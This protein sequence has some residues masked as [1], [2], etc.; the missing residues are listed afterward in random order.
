MRLSFGVFFYLCLLGYQAFAQEKAKLPDPSK[1]T[2]VSL[3]EILLYAEEHSPL[4]ISAKS[5][6]RRAE[7]EKTAAALPFLYNPQLSLALGPRTGAEDTSL[8]IQASFG[9]AFE[10]SGQ[11]ALRLKTASLTQ[12]TIG[13][14][15]EIVRWQIHS[16]VHQAYH[17]ALLARERVKVAERLLSFAEKTVEIIKKRLA[18]GDVSPLAVK[19]SESDASQAKQAKLSADSAYRLSKIALAEAAGWPVTSPP[20]PEGNLEDPQKAPPFEA[21]LQIALQNKPELRSYEA[22][23][24]EASAKE[25]LAEKEAAAVPFFG[26]NLNVEGASAG[27]TEIIA[28]A[29]LGMT[30]PIW[31]K[32]QGDRARALAEKSIAEAQREALT[33]SLQGRIAR[34]IEGINAN[35]ERIALYGKEILPTF[36]Q[37]LAL[38]QKAFE[39]G[40]IDILEV[41][42]ARERFLAIESQA[43]DA[44]ADYYRAVAA[45]EAE[46][47]AELWPDEKH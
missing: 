19:L 35:V 9:Q 30:F 33:L 26:V 3:E 13:A 40:Q 38:L 23:A 6:F 7:A 36:E 17:E 45:L 44:Y 43:L 39:L 2:S 10:L 4:L 14:Q 22:A 47:G 21:L 15:L 5:Y 34:G 20:E 16:Q 28:L 41:G 18:A 25:K 32:N 27:A 8:D 12:E 31:Q 11:R 37:N 29:N 1:D 46:I 24:E 42:V